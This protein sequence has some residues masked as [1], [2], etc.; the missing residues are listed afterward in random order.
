M[1]RL[2]IMLIICC[3]A[4]T[5]GAQEHRFW[6]GGQGGMVWSLGDRPASEGGFD[7]DPAMQYGGSLGMRLGEGWLFSLEGGYSKLVSDDPLNLMVIGRD[8]VDFTSLRIGGTL[9]RLIFPSDN[10][11]NLSLGWGGGIYNWK[12]TDGGGTTYR[13]SSDAG[14]PIDFSASE[15][16]ISAA[17]EMPI[18]LARPVSLVLG[19]S[20][21]YLTGAGAEFADEINEAR[22]RW[23]V[24]A[25][26][27]LR[28]HFGSV[29]R[30]ER[31]ASDSA[32]QSPRPGQPR[33]S[34]LVGV[35]SDAD[36]VPDDND[37]CLGTPRGAEVDRNGCPTDSDGDGV[38][39]G[40]D[41]CQGTPAA[42]HGRVDIF[43][44]PVDSDYDGMPDYLD[45]CPNNLVG[46]QIDAQG[47]PVDEDADG[48]PNGLDDCPHTLPGIPVDKYGCIDA[49][50]FARPMVLRP[51]YE[52][53]F[54]EIDEQT[55]A[56]VEQLARVLTLLPEIRL[57]IYGYTDDIGPDAANQA[58]SDKRASRIKD[59]L[60]VYGVAQERITAAG[61]GE[62]NFVAS[63]QT[64]EGR[65]LNRRIEI[66]FH[67]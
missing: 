9:H 11:V 57:E 10:R 45:N 28:L 54:F 58:L 13:V 40:L 2:V 52:P 59:F 55:R 39:D 36:G 27:S 29:Q 64:A 4:A 33:A 25:G 5:V 53:G 7:F 32:W 67:K 56:K 35:D 30:S 62:S 3:L 16:F 49:G 34:R 61:R 14:V 6:L 50:L 20:A 46:A 26:V 1:C 37:R 38:M 24:N 15:L 43:G 48:V 23:F 8:E 17:M 66:I 12:A 60:V 19:G 42:A 22:P 31:W 63:N 51:D 41:D 65:A 47:C 44:C 18:R 21:D